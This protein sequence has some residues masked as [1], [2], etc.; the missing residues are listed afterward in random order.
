MAFIQRNFGPRFRALTFA[1]WDRPFAYGQR[2]RDQARRWLV[3]DRNRVRYQPP[4]PGG[5]VVE[6]IMLERF[7]EGLPARTAA[8]GWYHPPREP[9]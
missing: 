5:G 2:L 8:W 6:Q 3:P 7:I 9:L 1:E 4:D